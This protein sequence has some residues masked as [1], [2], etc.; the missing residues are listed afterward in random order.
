MNETNAL[1]QHEQAHDIA[2]R[3]ALTAAHA[4]EVTIRM[5][6]GL[7]ELGAVHRLF[8][9]IWSPDADTPPITVELLRALAAGGNYVAGAYDAD[10]LVGA[11]VGFFGAPADGVLHSHIAGVSASAQGRSVG[12]ALKLHQRAWAMRRGVST[13]AW[14]FDPLVGRNAHFNLAKLGGVAAEY[15]PN[16]YGN[17]P[18]AIN[19][20]IDSDRILVRWTLGA[21]SVKDACGGATTSADAAAELAGGARVALSVAHTGAPA[22]GETSDGRLLVGVPG[23]I[24]AMRRTDP[25]T[26]KDWRIA[27]RDVL[28]TLMADGRTVSGFDRA[29]WYVVAEKGLDR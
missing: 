4:S 24:E 3:E 11:C 17:I 29:G 23:D 10:V 7:E 19:G 14:T 12:F 6:S 26:S 16:F 13:I 21:D 28:G 27:L 15:H 5:L 1:L 2:V 18:D 9:T 22:L 8:D 25:P 20:G